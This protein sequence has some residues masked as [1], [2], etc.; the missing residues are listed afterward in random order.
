MTKESQYAVLSVM[1]PHAGEDAPAIF[2]RKINDVL[3]VKK[4]FWLI[5]SSRAKPDMVQSICKITAAQDRI[6]RCHFVE[7]ST[8]G[9]AQPTSQSVEA[10][11]YSAD[12]TNWLELPPGLSPV[13]G[14]INSSACALVFGELAF[15]KEATLDLWQYADGLNQTQPIIFRQGASTQCA[16]RSDTSHRADKMKSH[17]RR[18]LAVGILT[19]PYAVWL[20]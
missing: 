9:G 16:F 15:E 18:V 19:K 13:T 20:K 1:G 14:H 6:V 12:K 11:K 8:K 10:K 5:R 17:I 3:D 7:A 4:T 2:K